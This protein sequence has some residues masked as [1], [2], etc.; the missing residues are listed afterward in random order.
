MLKYNSHA[1]TGVELPADLW[2]W[3]EQ[4]RVQSRQDCRS[5]PRP[6]P[7]VSCEYHLLFRVDP[8]NPTQWEVRSGEIHQMAETCRLDILERTTGRLLE[9]ELQSK[10]LPPYASTCA[11]VHKTHSPPLVEA[12]KVKVES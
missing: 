2:Y 8:Q 4:M 10:P 1:T 7:N 12:S 5:G 6:C 11:V 3:L 9:T